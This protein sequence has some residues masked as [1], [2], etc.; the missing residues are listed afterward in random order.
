MEKNEVLNEQLDRYIIVGDTGGTN[1]RL[2]LSKEIRMQGKV[3]SYEC[4]KSI[5]LKKKDYKNYSHH[6]DQ[7]LETFN[8]V[9]QI[10]AYY[11]ETDVRF[12]N[13]AEGMAFSILFQDQLL[14]K[15]ADLFVQL[16]HKNTQNV[17]NQNSK[18]KFL[19]SMGTGIGTAIILP[20]P[21]GESSRSY[22]PRQKALC[23]KMNTHGCL[24]HFCCGFGVFLLHQFLKSQHPEL[25]TNLELEI[26]D[27]FQQERKKSVSLQECITYCAVNKTD[28]LCMMAIDFLIE[29]FATCLAKFALVVLPMGG[30]YI[31]GG[32][33][34][35]LCDYIKDRKVASKEVYSD[36]E[37]EE[38][39]QGLFWKYFLT[40]SPMKE[41][42]LEKIPIYIMRENPTL[43]GLEAMLLSECI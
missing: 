28:K 31:S 26:Q 32:V 12:V 23:E 36:E 15:R 41:L 39:P 19:F 33:A 1:F 35:Y 18:V 21:N 43:D 13:D 27:K 14:S 22:N 24:N 40:D 5:Q 7:L 9:Q 8:T 3:V 6:I 34:N 11:K 42:V 16:R 2:R 25:I 10:Q 38:Q 4:V 29:I 20:Y 37:E 17:I 30:I